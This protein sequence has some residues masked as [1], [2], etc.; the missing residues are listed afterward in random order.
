MIKIVHV[1]NQFFAGL[2]GEEKAG[3]PVGVIEGSAGAARALEIKLGVEAKIIST[4]YVGDNYFHEQKDE[5][6]KAVLEAVRAAE[7]QV[8]VAGPAFNS[9]RYGMTCVE[10]CNSIANELVIPCITAMHGENPG[11]DAYREFANIRVYCLPTAETTAGM[12]DAMTRSH[13]VSLAV[14]ISARPGK[15]D[16]SAAASDASKKPSAVARRAPWKCCSRRYTTS[17]SAANCRWKFGTTRLRRRRSLR[18]KIVI[19]PL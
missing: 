9:G 8:L 17:R 16:I 7:P 13:V 11:V 2:G 4:I 12:T 6:V 15:K 14:K 5:A 3:L 18:P 19:L 10:V 1:V